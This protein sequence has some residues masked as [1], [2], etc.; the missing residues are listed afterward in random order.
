MA[1]PENIFHKTNPMAGHVIFAKKQDFIEDVNGSML[2]T[3]N[4]LKKYNIPLKHL[5]TTKEYKKA[6]RENLSEEDSL[7][8]ALSKNVHQIKDKIR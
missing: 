4:L 7:E 6:R 5:K 1:I 8:I 2:S 3:K